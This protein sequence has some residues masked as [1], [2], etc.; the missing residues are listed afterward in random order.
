MEF[1]LLRA[2]NKEKAGRS[3]NEPQIFMNKKFEEGKKLLIKIAFGVGY[4]ECELEYEICIEKIT[5]KTI[6]YN[7]RKRNTLLWGQ[8]YNG[9]FGE[10]KNGSSRL[11]ICAPVST[12]DR[13]FIIKDGSTEIYISE[14]RAA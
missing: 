11:K 8:E 1:I 5:D 9:S 12:P 7:Y 4:D 13:Y 14:N 10:R 2:L 6:K 3:R